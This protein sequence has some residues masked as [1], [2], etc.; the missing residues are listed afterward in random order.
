[1][2][3]EYSLRE[4]ELYDILVAELSNGNASNS[5]RLT[6]N[7]QFIKQIRTWIA[8]SSATSSNSK[9]SGK[10]NN[11]TPRDYSSDPST[12]YE[13]LSAGNSPQRPG[14]YV[15][16]SDVPVSFLPPAAASTTMVNSIAELDQL[17]AAN[18]FSVKAST[19]ARVIMSGHTL[20]YPM[21][22]QGKRWRVCS[23]VFIQDFYPSLTTLCVH[24]LVNAKS[25]GT[26]SYRNNVYVCLS[27]GCS[28]REMDLLE[29]LSE[30][31][32]C[33]LSPDLYDTSTAPEEYNGLLRPGKTSLR[34]IARREHG[35]LLGLNTNRNDVRRCRKDS[36]GT[37]YG[38]KGG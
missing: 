20:I 25:I 26:V 24:T 32:C 38:E 4:E 16:D 29:Y 14:Q 15:G 36:H 21:N 28:G 30:E 17:I 9:L 22:R 10:N 6:R 5:S 3:D 11:Y 18:P 31:Y 33:D 1:M 13:S 8:E 23:T 7:S 19:F 2:L 37:V 35:S 27:V 34:F 12:N